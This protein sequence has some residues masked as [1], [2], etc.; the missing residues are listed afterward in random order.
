MTNAIWILFITGLAIV[1]QMMV[2]IRA[3][4]K[5]VRIERAFTKKRLFEGERMQMVETIENRR[6]LPVPWLRIETRMP[7]SL[8]FGETDNLEIEGTRYHRSIFFLSPWQRVRRTHEVLAAK[9]GYYSLQSASLTVGDLLNIKRETSS[10]AMRENVTVYPR[11]LSREEIALPA[12]RWQGEAI[13][14]RFIQPD[15]F[16]YNGI[17]EY[18]PGDAIRDVHWRAYARTGSLQVK[19]HDY[20]AASKLMVLLNIAPQEQLWGEIGSQHLDQMEQA[21]RTAASIVHFA[22]EDGFDVGF[23]SNADLIGFEG[24]PVFMAP[25]SGPQQRERIME[26]LA[27]LRVKRAL[28]FHAYL[29]QLPPVSDMDIV[30]LSAYRS[31]LIDAQLERLRSNANTVTHHPFPLK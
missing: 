6:M 18:R 15:P 25:S 8:F 24:R 11:L 13:I 28:N 5:N 4:L 2:F 7:A 29:E 16:L 31:E 14:R 12:S 20:T 3:G 17:R 19:Q 23:G 26:A 21:I 30:I 1:L 10:H 27:R 22:L 9:R